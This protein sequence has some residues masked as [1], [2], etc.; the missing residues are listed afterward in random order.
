MEFNEVENLSEAQIME[1]Y[2]EVVEGPDPR[3]AASYFYFYDDEDGGHWICE[4]LGA[5]C[6]ESDQRH[7]WSDL[8][9]NYKTGQSKMVDTPASGYGGCDPTK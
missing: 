7:I 3:T 6:R 2:N 4:R 9:Y 1:L 5:Y 8:C